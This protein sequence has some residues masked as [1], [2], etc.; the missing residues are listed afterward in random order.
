[1]RRVFITTNNF[2][3]LWLDLGYSDDEMKSLEDALIN[4]PELGKV[5]KSTGGLRKLRWGIKGRG[6]SGGIRILY[7]DFPKYEKLFFISL[8]KKSENDDISFNSKKTFTK[9]II[10]IEKSLEEKQY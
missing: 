9:L 5:I 4:K 10:E 2:W 1:M 8:I 7:I 6:K 3:R